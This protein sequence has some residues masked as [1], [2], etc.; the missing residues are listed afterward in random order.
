[1]GLLGGGCG[2][3]E[4]MEIEGGGRAGRGRTEYGAVE[5]RVWQSVLGSGG[6]MKWCTARDETDELCRIVDD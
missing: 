1:V 2:V 6:V 4:I 5:D 3:E